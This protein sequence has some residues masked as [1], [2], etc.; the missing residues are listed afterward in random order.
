MITVWVVV[1]VVVGKGKINESYYSPFIHQI[2][3]GDLF[4]I[5]LQNKNM[6]YILLFS[7]YLMKKWRFKEAK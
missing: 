3:L 6:G 2:L 5:N 4:M 7:F 1:A